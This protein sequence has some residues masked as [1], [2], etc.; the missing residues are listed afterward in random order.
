VATTLRLAQ[1]SFGCGYGAMGLDR[2]TG[3]TKS[4]L[5]PGQ[6]RTVEIIESLCFG[7]I[8]H[9]LIRGGL[10]CYDPKPRIVQTIKLSSEPE[11]P[12]ARS[13]ADLTMKKEFETLFD[14]LSRLDDATVDIEIRHGLPFRLVLERRHKELL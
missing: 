14:Q 1:D 4:S 6:R 5:N 8:E 7:V 12:P 11:K 2:E 9:L 13:C 3:M 10:P